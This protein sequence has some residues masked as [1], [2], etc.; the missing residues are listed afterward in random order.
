M[1]KLRTSAWRDIEPVR[2][3]ARIAAVLCLLAASTVHAA[4]GLAIVSDTALRF[5][6]FVVP[7]TGSRTVTAAGQVT[8]TNVFPVS[9]AVTGPA[10]FTLTYDRGT[11]ATGQIL[12]TV[13]L[14]L[15][16]PGSFSQSGLKATVSSFDTDLQGIPLLTPG[17]S[18]LFAMPP[19]AS[20]VCTQVFHVGGRIDV[21]QPGNGGAV[22]VPLTI[23]AT[24]IAVL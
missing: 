21:T 3:L 2:R 7:G 12:V 20:P 8:N 14:T 17:Q 1:A 16:Q 24:L 22:T 19:C 18:L 23:G 4:P 10:Q 15:A 5:G 9:G 13:L 6:S 11:N